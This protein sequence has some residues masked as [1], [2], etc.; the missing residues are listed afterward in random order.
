MVIADVTESDLKIRQQFPGLGGVVPHRCHA[1]D[2][3]CLLGVPCFSL[4]HMPGGL[5]KIG[6]VRCGH[7]V[8]YSIGHC[9]YG[10]GRSAPHAFARLREPTIGVYF[11]HQCAYALVKI[12]GR[13]D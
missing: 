2:D 4:G 3:R 7:P 1:P 12:G 5:N 11:R 9:R 8:S 13:H 6:F 10:H